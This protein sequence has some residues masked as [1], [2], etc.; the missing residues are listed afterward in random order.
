MWLFTE[1]EKGSEESRIDIMFDRIMLTDLRDTVSKLNA[2]AFAELKSYK[3]P[4]KVIHNILVS[5]LALFYREKYEEGE[6][7]SWNTCKQVSDR[8]TSICINE[9]GFLIILHLYSVN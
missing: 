8:N 4:P 9:C 3:D 1:A 7:D 6:L 2:Q 5:V